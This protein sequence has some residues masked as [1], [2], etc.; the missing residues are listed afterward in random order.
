LKTRNQ[1]EMSRIAKPTTTR[2]MTAPER[3]ATV[4]PSL[5]ELLAAKAVR[6]LALVAIFMPNQPH[7]PES[8]PATGTPIMRE[9][10]L[11]LEQPHDREEGDEQ[12]EHARDDLVLAGEVRH[13]AVADGLGDADHVVVTLGLLH[14]RAREEV[15]AM[16]SAAMPP[17]GAR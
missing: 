12:D 5:S 7:R 15:I 16:M 13:R 8:R 10:A 9:R 4:R 6:A 2:P 1:T 3:K 11:E 14:H 17:T